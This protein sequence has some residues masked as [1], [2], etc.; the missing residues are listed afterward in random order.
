MSKPSLYIHHRYGTSPTPE[1]MPCA[2]AKHTLIKVL[3]KVSISSSV[4]DSPFLRNVVFMDSLTVCMFVQEETGRDKERLCETTS[5][6][7]GGIFAPLML[8][9]VSGSRRSAGTTTAPAPSTMCIRPVLSVFR[10]VLLCGP[11]VEVKSPIATMMRIRYDS[12]VR[13]RRRGGSRG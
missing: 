12:V 10:A 7:G 2:D 4:H 1:S 3:S 9:D 8:S 13:R 6:S 5:T 11:Y